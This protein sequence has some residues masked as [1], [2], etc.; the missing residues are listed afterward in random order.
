MN[1]E[2]IMRCEY[3]RDRDR[4]WMLFF[5]A[6][7]ILVALFTKEKLTITTWYYA[8]STIIQSL[9]AI[10]AMGGAFFI[11]KIPQIDK[12]VNDYR[13]RMI[14]FLSVRE[15][16]K[17]SYYYDLNDKEL[18]S[19][20]MNEIRNFEA[21]SNLVEFFK[22]Y[23]RIPLKGESQKKALENWL[24]FH[25]VFVEKRDDINK[26]LKKSLI[27]TGTTIVVTTL[28]LAGSDIFYKLTRYNTFILALSV[29]L[30]IVSTYY[31][32]STILKISKFDYL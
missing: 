28:L 22:D 9:A 15:G 14:H 32:A 4:K 5:L 2:E 24:K 30:F 7:V 19:V 16:N 1:F 13:N 11:F 23:E 27:L 29:Y 8:L 12:E 20:F 17:A 10:L 3:L 25:D 6:L 21:D 18:G 26:F 31:T